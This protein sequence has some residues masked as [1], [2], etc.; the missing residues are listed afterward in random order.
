M[1]VRSSA[2]VTGRTYVPPE[3]AT[4]RPIIKPILFTRYLSASGSPLT[5]ISA[6]GTI[7]LPK[8]AS[9]RESLVD[10]HSGL[11]FPPPCPH[12][13]YSYAETAVTLRIL[14]VKHLSRL[15]STSCP[16]DRGIGWNRWCRRFGLRTSRMVCGPA[17]PSREG[18]RR[19]HTP[20]DRTS[21]RCRRL[22]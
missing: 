5:R 12:N 22:L 19:N 4:I 9:G 15:S 7:R 1:P 3:H 17:L 14:R 2:A 8:A 13:S 18:E 21:R 6:D 10:R 11:A 16:R 20:E